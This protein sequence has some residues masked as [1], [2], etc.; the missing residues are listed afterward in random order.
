MYQENS[1]YIECLQIDDKLAG[2]ILM[3]LPC[4]TFANELHLELLLL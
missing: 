1:L 2:V 4:A 3:L